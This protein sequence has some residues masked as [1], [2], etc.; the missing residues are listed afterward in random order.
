MSTERFSPGGLNLSDRSD[1]LLLETA[2]SLS[3]VTLTQ[4]TALQIFPVQ[5]LQALSLLCTV[6]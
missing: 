5:F 2:H 6:Q 4:D 3:S 1:V